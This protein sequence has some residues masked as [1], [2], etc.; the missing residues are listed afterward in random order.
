MKK[1]IALSLALCFVAVTLSAQQDSV[2]TDG[3]LQ[4]PRACHFQ[5]KQA[6]EVESLV[7]MYLTGGYHLGLGY[8]YN[9]WRVRVSVI[10]GGD[11]NAEPA[12]LKNNKDEFKRYY[13]TSPGVFLGYNIWQNIDIYTYIE[14]HTFSIEQKSTGIKKDLYSTDFGGGIG[15]QLFI[16]P[17]FYIQ[18]AVHLYLRG[19]HSVNFGSSS[20]HIPGADFSPVLR[21][22][23]RL[24]KE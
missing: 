13:K 5:V 9:K 19:E 12:G 24:W 7:P 20:Y 16:G 8:R 6:F 4:E 3:G 15:Y 23:V 17:W 14:F 1:L 22:G 18:P 21:L 10:N 2:K 11:Y